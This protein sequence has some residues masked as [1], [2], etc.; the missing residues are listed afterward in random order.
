MLIAHVPLVPFEPM[1]EAAK[2]TLNKL[3]FAGN[4]RLILVDETL[5]NRILS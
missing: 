2:E 3:P 4:S 1:A 5:V